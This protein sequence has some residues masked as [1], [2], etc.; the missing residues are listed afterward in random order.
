MEP[1]KDPSA[2]ARRNQRVALA[3]LMGL[4]FLVVCWMAAPILVGLALGRVMGFTAQPLYSKLSKRLGQ[5]RKLA[6]AATTLLGGL[7]AVG[8]GTA[9]AWVIV[10]ELVVAV[11]TAQAQ[12]AA[13]TLAGPRATRVLTALGLDHD[14][15]IGRLRDEV[16]RVANLAATAAGVI[17]QASAGALLTIVIAMWTMYYVLLDWPRI[18]RHLERLLPLDPSHTRALV[19]EFR[20][21]GRRA[22]VGTVATALIQGILAGLGFAIFGVPHPVTGGAILAV[23]SFIPVIGT[24]LVWVPAAVWLLT[25]GH[26]A[27]ALLLTGYCL[28]V[29]MAANDYVIRPRL[30]GSSDGAHPLLTLVALIG[31]I[32]V[33]GVA[34]VIVGPVILSLFV[35]SAR[36]YERERE[37]DL[38]GSGDLGDRTWGPRRPQARRAEPPRRARPPGGPGGRQR[39]HQRRN[40]RVAIPAT[41]TVPTAMTRPAPLRIARRSTQLIAS[42]AIEET[43]AAARCIVR[44]AR[45]ASAGARTMHC[46]ARRTRR[47]VSW[48]TI[49]DS[50]RQES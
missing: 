46:A 2:P 31:G 20:D 33:F 14:A 42:S 4:T 47:I 17:V 43:I 26:L 16:G 23:T 32:S 41:L 25:A 3:V 22:F 34:G 35:A 19:A 29:V 5:R 21:V 37:Q 45:S 9:A 30:V 7:M 13:G 38:E 49:S 11:A 28:I 48:R 27:R 12:I 40:R 8:G 15:V 1:G 44:S 24:L 6:S 36:I 50:E 10:R 18:G 39:P